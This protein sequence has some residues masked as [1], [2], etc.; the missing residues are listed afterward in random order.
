MQRL[1]I[2]AAYIG[3]SAAAVDRYQSARERMVRDQIEAG[4]FQAEVYAEGFVVL[5]T[6]AGGLALV[7]Y[8]AV[9]R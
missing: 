2:L 9:N 3:L 1:I 7:G 4:R 6:L 8:L 5:L